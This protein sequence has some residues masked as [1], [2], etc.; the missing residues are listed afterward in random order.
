MAG[1][2]T[3]TGEFGKQAEQWSHA[4]TLE[5]GKVISTSSPLVRLGMGW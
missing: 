3:Q 1:T 2:E 5:K 4:G